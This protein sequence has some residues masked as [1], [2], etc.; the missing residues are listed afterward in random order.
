MNSTEQFHHKIDRMY[1]VADPYIA[2]CLASTRYMK[3]FFVPVEHVAF[4]PGPSP[5]LQA[6]AYETEFWANDSR[7]VIHWR[8]RNTWPSGHPGWQEFQQLFLAEV[9]GNEGSDGHTVYRLQGWRFV[10]EFRLKMHHDLS[11][12]RSQLPLAMD[13]TYRSSYLDSDL[14]RCNSSMLIVEKRHHMDPG[15]YPRQIDSCNSLEFRFIDGA[16][17]CVQCGAT[18]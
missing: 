4:E 2:R 8:E 10:Q 14:C 18:K 12:Q 5:V 17:V 1:V 15:D 11:C 16:T 3:T 13:D 6:R 9:W 7:N